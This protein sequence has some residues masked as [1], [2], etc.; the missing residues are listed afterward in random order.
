MVP[1]RFPCSTVISQAHHHVSFADPAPKPPAVKRLPIEEL[2]LLRRAP[3]R[4]LPYPE[5]EVEEHPA[6]PVSNFAPPA[7]GDEG[8]SLRCDY[9]TLEI[10]RTP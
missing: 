5:L 9:R 6:A 2:G 8:V 7:A 10:Y 4:T 1:P 3:Q